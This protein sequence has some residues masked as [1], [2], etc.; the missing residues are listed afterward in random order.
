MR[1]DETA[2]EVRRL[3]AA[4]DTFEPLGLDPLPMAGAL[5]EALE[6]PRE[7]NIR[8]DSSALL[9]DWLAR[10]LRRKSA[11]PGK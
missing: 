3:L 10:R 5:R 1:A 7:S 2:P 11:P 8:L 6:A 9:D 4:A